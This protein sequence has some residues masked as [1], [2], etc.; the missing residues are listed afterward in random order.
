MPSNTP[1]FPA[2]CLARAHLLGHGCDCVVAVD[3][4]VRL[5]ARSSQSR[6]EPSWVGV[7]HASGE[8]PVLDQGNVCG[9]LALANG[10]F[11]RGQ[12]FALAKMVRR[13][14]EETLEVSATGSAALVRVSGRNKPVKHEPLE[15]SPSPSEIVPRPTRTELP[16]QR[17]I[18][19]IE[20]A[21]DA[22]IIALIAPSGFGKSTVLAQYLRASSR[23][24]V[25]IHV[26]P[27]D[28]D[29]SRLL[30]HLLRGLDA[31]SMTRTSE[32]WNQ[33][34]E[35]GFEQLSGRLNDESDNF[36]LVF[37]EINRLGLEARHGLWRFVN[38]LAE[39]HR[40]FLSGYDLEH[41]RVARAVAEGSAVVLGPQDLAF[42]AD[43]TEAYLTARGYVGDA[44]QVHAALEG[45][46]AGLALVAAGS[47]G[48][49]AP[50]N[51]VLDALDSLTS[52][53]RQQIAQAAVLDV[54]S[55][56]SARD[57]GTDLPV[58]WVLEV[59]RAGLP[60][61]PL[62]DGRFQP[63][64]VLM[65]A[66]ERE[67]R[68]DARRHKQLHRLAGRVCER[69]GFFVRAAQHYQAAGDRRDLLHALNTFTR[70]LVEA[71][72]FHLLRDVLESVPQDQLEPHLRV[73]LA[74]CY[75]ETGLVARAEGLLQHLQVSGADRIALLYT[76]CVLAA[77]RGQY[78][79]LLALCDEADTLGQ[80]RGTPSL[81]R[82]RAVAHASLGQ[83]EAA[84]AAI[85][86][87]LE[88]AEAQNAVHV[89]AAACASAQ[90]VF[91]VLGDAARRQHYLRRGIE[92]FQ[93]LNE[94]TQVLE[95]YNDLADLYR[96][97]GRFEEASALLDQAME[98]ASQEPNAMQ[99]LLLEVRGDLS[100]FQDQSAQAVDAYRQALET[101]VSYGV[102][103]I[104]ARIRFKLSE[105]CERVGDER[106]AQQWLDI[107][108]L[109]SGAYPPWVAAFA[110]FRQAQIA[111]GESRDEDVVRYVQETLVHTLEPSHRL[112]GQAYLAEV[113]RRQGKLEAATIESLFETADAIGSDSALLPDL[114]RLQA[115]IHECLTRDLCKGRWQR[116]AQRDAARDASIP[117]RGVKLEIRTLGGL[118]VTLNGHA[119]RFP[120][121][122]AGELLVWLSLNT[123]ATR[124]QALDALWDGND[125]RRNIEYFK[126][127]ARRLRTCLTEQGQVAFNPLPYEDGR[128]RLAEAMKLEVDVR[129]LTSV[130]QHTSPADLETLLESYGGPFLPQS[131]GEWAEVTRSTAHE[132]VLEV[133]LRLGATLLTRDAV[134][135]RVVYERLVQL[136]W[137]HEPSHVGA[138]QAALQSNDPI[139]AR[140]L[141]GRYVKMLQEEFGT[142]P[143]ADLV[144]RFASL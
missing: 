40:V 34:P 101:A 45:W 50:S 15:R 134:A 86:R 115:L 114:T 22:K 48:H 122:K 24:T 80:G 132:H 61:A 100:F 37:D 142:V 57:V 105:A 78:G 70:K 3:E 62:G 55:E 135:A 47:S 6:G 5:E 84:R 25:W 102:D 52:D 98:I 120:F 125:L 97:Q 29:P 14:Y 26:Q 79:L 130:H 141:Y 137:L 111:L 133:G 33:S 18:E 104:A 93:G 2:R 72:R 42:D 30:E 116:L 106:A 82:F 118:Q 95:L 124:D 10:G 117:E 129:E 138:I 31:A 73:S 28:A 1:L 39:G 44:R 113:T 56:E 144:A 17:L 131:R 77:R 66:L 63:H 121:A 112:R 7:S 54:W 99:A 51:L 23:P 108:G 74:R 35:R 87:A 36:N 110:A 38:G 65:D 140:R 68:S 19:R 64:Q 21:A 32:D 127:T 16:R 88:W 92:L 43:E 8:T 60:I 103:L 11:A 85:H 119:I 81:D 9:T 107:T 139:A 90:F 128:Y 136:D 49:I 41:L 143:D 75:L 94:P 13:R 20:A 59:Q 91:F 12:R 46:P 27:D 71:G 58:G 83:I 4:A 126:L 67:L 53:L 89:Q 109:D 76:R 69:Q 123:P 96:H